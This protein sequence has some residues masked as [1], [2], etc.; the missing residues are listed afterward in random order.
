VDGMA[1]HMRLNLNRIAP[2]DDRAKNFEQAEGQIGSLTITQPQSD[3]LQREKLSEVEDL[4]KRRRKST[5]RWES[6]TRRRRRHSRVNTPRRRIDG[7]ARFEK[8]SGHEIA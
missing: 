5:L 2:L 4:K 7:I 1:R 3:D 8:G 6:F